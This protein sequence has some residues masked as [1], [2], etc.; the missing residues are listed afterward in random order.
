[1]TPFCLWQL[2]KI[3]FEFA[4]DK[5]TFKG[6]HTTEF[7]DKL[8]YEVHTVLKYIKIFTLVKF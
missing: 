8:G 2:T 6:T 1:M 3:T 4:I 7:V 5:I